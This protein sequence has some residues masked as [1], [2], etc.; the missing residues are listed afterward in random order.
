MTDQKDY[1][2]AEML[3]A[4]LDGELG[5]D[6]RARLLARMQEDKSLSAE[7]CELR[8]VKDAVQLAHMDVQQ[9][10]RYR[11]RQRQVRW[12]SVAAG[13]VLFVFGILLGGVISKPEFGGQRFA[14]LDPQGYGQAP[15]VAEN[16]EMR[17]VFHLTDPD[18][19][20][21]DDLLDEVEEVLQEYQQSAKPLRVEVVANNEGLNLFREGLTVHADRI[22]E[23]SR[24]WP[25]LTFVAC[26]NT[27][28]RLKVEDGIEVVLLPQA[29][30]TE[31]GV[32]HVAR[33]QQE[34]WAYIRL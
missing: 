8:M 3:N 28:Q 30:V 22:A 9:P 33:R 11:R 21:A 24:T 23:M 31:S 7:F 15:A 5:S 34:G 2:S 13:L 1:P 16:K 10:A 29:E 32:N 27:I 14:I 4:L 19:L 20:T 17:I 6:E 26:Q 18:S 25:N 12:F